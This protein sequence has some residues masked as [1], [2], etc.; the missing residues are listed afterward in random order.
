MHERDIAAAADAAETRRRRRR[1]SLAERSH[2]E[3]RPTGRRFRAWRPPA[4]GAIVRDIASPA[5]LADVVAAGLPVVVDLAAY[6]GD[7]WSQQFRLLTGETP[8]D[9]TGVTLAAS[10]R[11]KLG[12]PSFALV[13][14]VEG[15]PVDGT[16]TLSLPPGGEVP[17]GRYDYDLE[18]TTGDEAGTVTTWVRGQLRVDRD[19]TNELPPPG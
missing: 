8:T 11:G 14:T 6:R 7:T 5:A 3:R 10:C 9:L 13:A 18:A 15:D 4:A 16:V 17:Y 2:R 19:V 1:R 12:A